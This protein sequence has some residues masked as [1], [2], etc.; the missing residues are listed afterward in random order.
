MTLRRGLA[1]AAS[2]ACRPNSITRSPESLLVACLGLVCQP[3]FFAGLLG[4]DLC[5]RMF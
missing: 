5:R 1:S 2:A 3:A 4:L